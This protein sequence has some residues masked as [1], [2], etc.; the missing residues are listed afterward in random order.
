MNEVQQYIER[1]N[2]HS[3]NNERFETQKMQKRLSTEL[4]TLHAICLHNPEAAVAYALATG[5]NV[6]QKGPFGFTPLH[7]LT[8]H[9]ASKRYFGKATLDAINETAIGLLALG[10]DPI[11]M[12][13]LQLNAC[14]VGEGFCPP[15]IQQA[16]SERTD[17]TVHEHIPG[18]K[19]KRIPQP[20]RTKRTH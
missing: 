7:F 12:C 20:L 4:P 9:Y 3:I 1:K 11:Q 17:R 13:D 2:N 8:L 15:A 18:E 14:A 16:V 19:V 5:C 10:A 6:N